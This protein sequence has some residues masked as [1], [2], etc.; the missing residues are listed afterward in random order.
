MYSVDQK[1]I[2]ERVLITLAIDGKLKHG[3]GILNLAYQNV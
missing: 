3:C 2:M 1:L